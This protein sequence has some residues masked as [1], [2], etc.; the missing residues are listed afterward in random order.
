MEEL[1]RQLI[2]RHIP[3]TIDVAKVMA[4]K[5]DVVHVE[6]VATEKDFFKCRINATEVNGSNKLKITPKVGSTVIIGI[7]KGTEKAVI[8][9]V[10]EVEHVAF[11]IENTICEVDA[12]GYK[13]ARNGQNLKTVLNDYIDEV[14]KIVVLNG[15]TINVVAT[16]AIK[17]RLN[18]ILK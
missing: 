2:E 17:T 18:E 1:I 7:F 5:G 9:S 12:S 10:S 14:N 13:V 4:I 8:L 11:Q 16:T 3:I 15:T 6:S